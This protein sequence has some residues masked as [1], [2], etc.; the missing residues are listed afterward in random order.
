MRTMGNTSGVL[1]ASEAD[2]T[3]VPWGKLNE[4]MPQAL[5]RFQAAAR[6]ELGV[7]RSGAQTSDP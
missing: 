4:D 7:D 3:G 1:H 2:M 6:A 5:R